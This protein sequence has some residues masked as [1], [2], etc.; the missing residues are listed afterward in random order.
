[1]TGSRSETVA[2]GERVA[3][4]M[5][6]GD[7]V[8]LTGD[9][10]AGKTA[11]SSGF[12]LGLGSAEPVTSPTFTIMREHKLPSGS[13]APLVL[14]LDAYRL[15]SPDDAED[16]GLLELLDRGAVAIIE[17]GERIMNALGPDRLWVRFAHDDL[18]D[19]VRVIEFVGVGARW[20]GVDL[21]AVVSC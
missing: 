9:L 10:G 20:H 2:L 21:G 4:L 6:P 3:A 11:F 18:D 19:D 15:D 14:H 5:R 7:V 1:M 17:W 12:I 8:I 16:I 13:V